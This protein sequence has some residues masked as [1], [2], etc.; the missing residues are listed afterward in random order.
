[1][2]KFKFMNEEMQET[3]TGLTGT[4]F[5]D[6]VLG[7]GAECANRGVWTGITAAAVA[8]GLYKLV[9]YGVKNINVFDNKVIGKIAEDVVKR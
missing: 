5:K 2:K 7:Y 3:I 8:F 4:E 6:A 9:A 1:M